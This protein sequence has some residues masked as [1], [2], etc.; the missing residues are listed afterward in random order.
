MDMTII[1]SFLGAS[2]RGET[3][4]IGRNDNT[5]LRIGEVKKIIY[6]DDDKSI[7]KAFIEYAV[8]VSHKDANG[9]STAVPYIACLLQNVF[10][11]KADKLKYTFRPDKQSDNDDSDTIW[12]VGSK[13]LILCLN[14]DQD[15]AI[16]M[17]GI[18]DT[19]TD[20]E[21][22]EKDEGHNLFFE[23]N[24]VQVTINKDGELSLMFRGATDEKGELQSSANSDAEGSTITIDKEG[25]LKF[26]TPKDDQFLTINHKDKK[27]EMQ[28]QKEW[29]TTI[30][31]TVNINADDN[32]IIKS[33]GVKV[34]DATDFWMLGSTYR[35]AEGQMNS[36][37]SGYLS[38]VETLL[39]TAASLLQSAAAA[40]AVP[41][42]GGAAA[43]TPFEGAAAAIEAAGVL[44]GEAG[45][46]MTTFESSAST[47]LSTKNKND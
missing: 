29:N 36:E 2:I 35:Q 33:S 3:G 40:N 42:T 24:G 21:M 19:G 26:A 44:V 17:G 8:E 37:I 5:L 14:G 34:G 10:G 30:K 27:I 39:N 31:G 38:S 7:S 22:K 9:I 28:A 13:V 45:T 46:A 25:T 20:P 12:G 23:F 43:A 32:V 4:S 18:N 1:P 47:Y 16:I 11:G 41:M 6:P 15:N